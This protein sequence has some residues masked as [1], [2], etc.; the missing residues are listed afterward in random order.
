MKSTQI[1]QPQHRKRQPNRQKAREIVFDSTNEIS[2]VGIYLN[3]S[4]LNILSYPSKRLDNGTSINA[5]SMLKQ[6]TQ[7]CESPLPGAEIEAGKKI[8]MLRQ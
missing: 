2:N 3:Q 6:I 1:G 8:D 4:Q 7:L 5:I